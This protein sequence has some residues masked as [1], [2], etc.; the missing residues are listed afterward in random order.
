MK[1]LLKFSVASLALT[2]ILLN[3]CASHHRGVIHDGAPDFDVDVSKI[4]NAKPK[5]EPV[6]RYGNPASY[7][8]LG[9]EYKPL[10]TNLGYD[11]R[12]LASW[13][14]TKFHQQLTSCRE[15]YDMLS[16]SA[17][18]KTLP[19]PCYVRVTNLSNNK[20]VIVRV[21]DRGPFHDNRIIDLSFAAAKKL[22]IYPA[23]T[24]MVQVTAIDPNHPDI[25]PSLLPEQKDLKLF[26]QIGAF[27]LRENADHLVERIQELTG[28]KV[29]VNNA[30]L[31][32][33]AIYKVRIGPLAN[34]NE[35]ND[36][37]QKLQAAGIGTAMTVI[38]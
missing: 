1:R 2:L 31:N 11:E 16:M 23:G 24:G 22:G 21:N 7:V 32:E 38:E 10:K 12:G 15:P 25:V 29:A 18:H 17:A 3:G 5:V 35:S 26:L 8:A 33:Q 20:Q 28:A 27:A 19:I 13:Y 34:S 36:I 37:H 4:P 14:G 6:S 9:K 30:S